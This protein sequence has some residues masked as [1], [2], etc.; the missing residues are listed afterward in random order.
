M[1]IYEYRCDACKTVFEEWHRHADD[2]TEVPCPECRTAAHRLISNTSFVL[3]GG[4]WYVTEYGNRKTDSA[5]GATAASTGTAESAPAPETK[6]E[7]APPAAPAAKTETA[8]A[9]AS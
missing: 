2:I 3:K 1:P 6:T 4:G 8:A 9:A 5:S 7:T